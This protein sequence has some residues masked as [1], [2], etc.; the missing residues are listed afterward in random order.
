VDAT[1]YTIPT[2]APEADGTL[3]PADGVIRPD[4]D[5]PGNGLA[6]RTADAEPFR[7]GQD[8]LGV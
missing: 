1:A 4:P 8:T 2:D 7:E 6:L 3:D 5:A